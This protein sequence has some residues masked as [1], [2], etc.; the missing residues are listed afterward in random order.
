MLRRIL[1]CFKEATNQAR[2]F[3]AAKETIILIRL[4]LAS[5]PRP[6]FFIGG[7]EKRT[8]YTLSAHASNPPRNPG[9]LD[10]SVKYHVYCPCNEHK[11]SVILLVIST[12]RLL[13]TLA[14]IFL[15]ENSSR[16][17]LLSRQGS[18]ASSKAKFGRTRRR[19]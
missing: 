12:V 18:R 9:A 4:L 7:G 11:L 16:R 15:H 14:G 19:V 2:S 17:L 6:L 10:S 8:W 3:R 1:I 5:S 13:W